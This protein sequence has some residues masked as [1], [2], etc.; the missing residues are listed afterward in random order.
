ME[1]INNKKVSMTGQLF[2]YALLSNLLASLLTVVYFSLPLI[3]GYA[4]GGLHDLG[5]FAVMLVC[6]L[7]GIIGGLSTVLL[8]L[9]VWV[10]NKILGKLDKNIY[11]D[12]PL[13]VIVSIVSNTFIILVYS[14]LNAF[15]ESTIIAASIFAISALFIAFFSHNNFIKMQRRLEQNNQI[16]QQS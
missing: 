5:I 3:F 2:I 12:L 15:D 16:V 14:L 8:T 7:F 13:L 11:N 9:V 6:V 4:E 1:E 10:I